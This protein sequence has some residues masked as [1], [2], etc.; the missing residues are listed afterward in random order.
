MKTNKLVAVTALGLALN[1]GSVFANEAHH[2]E[3]AAQDGAT[4]TQTTT[5]TA[6]MTPGA[7]MA[8]KKAMM[9][10]HMGG[11]SGM[12][13]MQGMMGKSMGGEGMPMMKNMMS[14]HKDM[15]S[16]LNLID[17]RLAKMEVLLE[18]LNR[19]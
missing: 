4:S 7:G 14:K 6:G 5:Q 2:P 17:A 9:S 18:N 11:E 13:T 16:R 3:A 10:K 19:Q 1:M 8:A 12:P 15:V